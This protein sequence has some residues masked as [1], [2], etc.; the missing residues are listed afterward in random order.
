MHTLLLNPLSPLVLRTGKPFGDTGG[1]DSF[2]FPLPSTLA[3][4]LRTAHADTL[5]LHFKQEEQPRILAWQS[6][7]ALPA[8][9]VGDLVEALFPKPQDANYAQPDETLILQ[10]LS[11]IGVTDGE[12]CD[13]PDGLKPV[14]LEA[15]DKAKPAAG[16]VWWTQEVMTDWLLGNQPDQFD[17]AKLGPNALPIELRN[18]VALKPETLSA[19]T[20]QLFQSS[21]PDFGNRRSNK[22]G[23]DLKNRGWET[24]RYG[25]LARFSEPIGEGVLR[26]GGEGRLTAVS[27]IE[28]AWP[29]LR[30]IVDSALKNAKR[31]RLILATPALFDG[32]W[33]P[34]WIGQGNEGS[35]PG[36]EGLKLRLC[37]AAIDRWQAI[38]G[39]D[40]LHRKPKAVRRMVPAGSV[41]WFE[42]V[43]VLPDDWASSLWLSAL[44]DQAQ[45][46]R[47]G[48]GLALPGLWI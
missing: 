16:P 11:P 13:L 3:G 24:E 25:L 12:Y 42:V 15:N 32:G 43:G 35:P 21:G 20:G 26:L 29:E 36:V 34:G 39:W 17:I 45:D 18:H 9:F 22:P 37:A 8:K 4:A 5:G 48:F 46:R 19:K 6:Q 47:D 10:R 33:K 44:S 1:D 14:F 38:S 27:H 7:G 23:H 40:L 28:N 41:Y 30:D 31:I 2:P